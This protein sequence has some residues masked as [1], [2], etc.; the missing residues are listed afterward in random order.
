MQKDKVMHELGMQTWGQGVR[1][2]QRIRV[3]GK[4]RGPVSQLRVLEELGKSRRSPVMTGTQTGSLAN[5]YRLENCVQRI[6]H[7]AREYRQEWNST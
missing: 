2:N 4:T 3:P 5:F 6:M 1:Q 7:T